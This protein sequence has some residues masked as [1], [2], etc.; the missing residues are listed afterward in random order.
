MIKTNIADDYVL[1]AG[2]LDNVVYLCLRYTANWTMRHADLA[3][4]LMM[5]RSLGHD[6]I[7]GNAGLDALIRTTCEYCWDHICG[8]PDSCTAD[9][10]YGHM[11]PAIEAWFAST[12]K[13]ERENTDPVP[14]S[15]L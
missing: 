14:E 8:E 13:E 7:R 2:E 5:T 10:F 4:C 15:E 11:V 1:S 6:E 3:V 12:S 9:D